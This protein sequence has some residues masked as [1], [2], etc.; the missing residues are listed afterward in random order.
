MAP[1]RLFYDLLLL[2]LIPRTR[3]QVIVL[4]ILSWAC[5]FAWYLWPAG[6]ATWAI[7]LLYLPCLLMVLRDQGEP[8][9]EE[10]GVF[11]MWRQLLQR[12]RGARGATG[13]HR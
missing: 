3:R 6:G 10:E 11:A 1:Q 9:A 13:V 2:W 5:Y 7:A 4:V 12:L 8:Q